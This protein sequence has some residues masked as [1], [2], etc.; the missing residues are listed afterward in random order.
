MNRPT[1]LTF[2]ATL[3]LVSAAPA[4]ASFHLMQIEQVAGSYCGNPNAQAI[5]L[6]M[7]SGGQQFVQGTSLVAYDATGANPVTLLTFP[8]NASN[9]TAGARILI[10]TVAFQQDAGA[11]P[12][13]FVMTAPIPASYLAAGRLGFQLGPSAYWAV[14]W[15][16]PAYTGTNL[17]TLDN[18]A[19]GDFNPPFASPMPEHGG[20][21]IFFPGTAAAMSTNNAADYALSPDP[22]LWANNLGTS[23]AAN[24]CVFDDDFES[25]DVTRWSSSQP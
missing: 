2:L 3:A 10:A 20:V 18:D 6:R 12:A 24:G 15:G 25:G 19:D 23:G 21:T 1:S 13:D 17:G 22:A 11:P 16:G 4:A 14:A 7:R 5:Q 9:G 8:A